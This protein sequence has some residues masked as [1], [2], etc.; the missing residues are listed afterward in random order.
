M[1]VE[2]GISLGIRPGAH[3]IAAAHEARRGDG[4]CFG[5]SDGVR[6]DQLIHRLRV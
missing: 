3:A 1:R 5:R 4:T 2:V 6:D